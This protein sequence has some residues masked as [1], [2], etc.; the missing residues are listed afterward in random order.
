MS[1]REL[2]Y[3]LVGAATLFVLWKVVQASNA[4]PLQ[5]NINPDNIKPDSISRALDKLTS[6]GVKV[7]DTPEETK[8]AAGA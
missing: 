7:N 8:N 2:Q 5:S 3:V 1:N 4:K 6:G